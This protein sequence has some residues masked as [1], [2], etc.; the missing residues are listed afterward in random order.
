MEVI[1]LSGS[2]RGDFGLECESFSTLGAT[3]PDG[4]RVANFWRR[5]SRFA[6]RKN[7]HGTIGAEFQFTEPAMPKQPFTHKPIFPRDP[8][9]RQER[10]QHGEKVK[11]QR[12]LA[13]RKTK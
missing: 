8:K 2:P 10:T 6:N 4:G 5:V 9:T 13:G 11:P 12:E 7:I 1:N 3:L